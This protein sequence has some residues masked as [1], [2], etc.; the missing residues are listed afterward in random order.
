VLKAV[1]VAGSNGAGKTTFARQMLP[2]LYPGVTF[3]NTDE[4][5]VE[6]RAYARPE[7]AGREFLRRLE[8]MERGRASFAPETTLSGK[9]HARRVVAWRGSGY[10]VDLHFLQL[11]SAD[12]AVRRVA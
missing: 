6:D 5:Q 3:L 4:I 8:R 9:L 2:L 1:I 10:R 12:L 11:P 7:A